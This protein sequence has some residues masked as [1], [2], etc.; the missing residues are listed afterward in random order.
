MA[1][2]EWELY[3]QTMA[4]MNYSGAN[5][6]LPRRAARLMAESVDPGNAAAIQ[7]GLTTLHAKELLSQIQAPTLVVYRDA[8]GFG[9]GDDSRHL[10]ASIQGAKLVSQPGESAVP[11]VGDIELSAGTVLSFLRGES[12]APSPGES[13]AAPLQTVLFTD[14]A[15]S[16]A[17]TQRLG[18]DG[19]QELLRAHDTIVRDALRSHGG[20]EVKHTGDGIMASFASASAALECA[21]AIQRAVAGHNAGEEGGRDPR[22]TTP[23]PIHVHVGI[24][25]GEPLAE[26]DDLF[27]TAVQ[28]ARRICDQA[29]AG[30]VLVSNVVRELTA[31]KGF[32]FADRGDA[33]LRGFEDPVRLYE[34]R[35]R[36]EPPAAS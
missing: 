21:I 9:R 19:A 33:A 26:S 5:D 28:L 35:W 34:L 10:A 36:E 2:Q 11:Y 16:T 15:G 13:R 14:L 27:G 23:D 8:L 22:P 30:E 20:V 6:D 25:A 18:D 3:N 31:G 12:T 32:L 24:N 29:N 7:E 4:N 17:L 1:A